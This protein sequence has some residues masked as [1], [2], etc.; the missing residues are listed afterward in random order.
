M[1]ITGLR[2]YQVDLPLCEGTYK[3]SGGKSVEVFDSTVVEILTDEGITGYGECCPLG[4]SYLPAY[5]QGVRAGLQTLA[6]H[7][8]GQDPTELTKIN[9]CMDAALKG[10]PYVKS[11]VDVACWDI[12][13]K[14]AGLPLVTLLGG[15]Q[16]EKYQ[17]Y[18]AISQGEPEAMAKNVQF[19]REQGYRKFQLKVGGNAQVD[20]ACIRAVRQVLDP[21]E[22]LVADANTAWLAHQA[23]QV[24]NGVKDVNVYIE[25]P[26]ETLEENWSVRQRCPLPFIIDENIDSL[27]VVTRIVSEK[28]AD[29]INL[30]ISK[31]GGITKARQI[32]DYCVA[33]G[34]AMNIEDTWGGDIVTAAI[35]H[36]AHS[37]PPRY[38]LCSTDFNSYVTV[39]IAHNAP[40]RQ[41]GWMAAPS[42]PGLGIQPKMEVLGKAVFE[43]LA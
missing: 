34:I 32:R 25:Q 39:S 38:L 31:V 28:M 37:C 24:I 13:G 40:Q 14:K 20:I 21:D 19:Y 23:I 12:L 26:C 18:R 30:K 5:A 35:S 36:L 16:G 22:V 27:G 41:N 42:G 10:H 43:L 6:P 4:P 1:R 3:F 8:M 2:F 7:L 11:A 33:H 15:R 9:E 17:L 29:C